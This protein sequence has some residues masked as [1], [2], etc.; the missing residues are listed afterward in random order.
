MPKAG[1]LVAAQLRRQ[2]ITGELSEGDPL[3]PET[4]LMERFGV[5]RPTL[6]EGFR[7]LESEQMIQVR[8][9]ARGG[10]RVLLPDVGTAAR[11]AGTLLQYRRTTLADVHEARVLLESSVLAVVAR[12]RTA[13]QLRAL[14]EKYAEGE[15]LL[16]DA[17]G[18]GQYEIEFH[19]LLVQSAGNQTMSVLLSI[20]SAI[21]ARHIEKFAREHRGDAAAESTTVAA[22]RAHGKL[23]R[24]IRERDVDNAV[25]FWR[26]Y[27]SRVKEFMIE[28]PDESVLDVLS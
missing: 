9:G 24:L 27:L 22:H 20:V 11:Y 3:M 19:R 4:E 23:I 17:P 13:A 12:K 21:I 2:I 7:I 5:S 18:F 8:R 1:E 14:E 25:T 16:D 26:R 15:A 10:A 28:N 6:R